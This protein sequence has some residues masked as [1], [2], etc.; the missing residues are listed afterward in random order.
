MLSLINPVRRPEPFDHP[1]WLFEAKFDGFRAAADTVRGHLISRNGNRMK[2]HE[3]VLDL[4]PQ[5]YVFDGELVVLDDTGRPLFN[6]LLFG[7]HRPTYVAFDVLFADG[8]DL[9][10]LPLRD[11]KTRLAKIAKGAEGWI[12]LTNGVVGEGRTLYQAVIAADLEGV[13]AKKLT[14][15]YNPKLTRWH[16]ILNRTYSQ[17]QGRAE[18]FRERQRRHPR[19]REQAL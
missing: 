2:R 14:D 10:P 15:P 1:D 7:D 18:W 3:E 9:R 16:K 17:R 12:A 4:L 5:G 13:V 6:K 8:V 19:R 11:R